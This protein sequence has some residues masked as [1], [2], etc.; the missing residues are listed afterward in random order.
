VSNGKTYRV[1]SKLIH[2]FNY[3]HMELSYPLN[4]RGQVDTVAW[5]HWCGLRDR[6]HDQKRAE[7]ALRAASGEQ[8]PGEKP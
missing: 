1:W 2:R 7:E 6:V 8:P 5:C 3:H 4:E